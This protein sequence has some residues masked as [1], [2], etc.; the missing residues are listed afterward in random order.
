MPM[1]PKD[2][3]PGHFRV[4]MVKSFVRILAAIFLIN[5]AFT[6]AGVMIVLAEIFGV[7]EEMV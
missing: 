2:V 7:L 5:Q 3:S 1:Q 6:W 4:S